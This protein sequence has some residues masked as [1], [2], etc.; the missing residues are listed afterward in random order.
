MGQPSYLTKETRNGSPIRID[1]PLLKASLRHCI[2]L[3]LTYHQSGAKDY[4]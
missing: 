4:P 2:A 1:P 3:A